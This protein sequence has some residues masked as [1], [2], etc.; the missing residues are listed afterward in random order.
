MKVSMTTALLVAIASAE[1]A[2]PVREEI[3]N[4]INKSGAKWQATPL[5]DN[6]LRHIPVE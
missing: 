2:H 3:I 1:T 4:Q 6:F 5:E